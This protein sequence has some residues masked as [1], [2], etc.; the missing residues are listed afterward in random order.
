V[1]WSA[2]FPPKNFENIRPYPASSLAAGAGRQIRAKHEPQLS[3]F[4]SFPKGICSRSISKCNIFI[5]RR[6]MLYGEDLQAADDGRSLSDSNA[7]IDVLEPGGY[8]RRAPTGA[9]DHHPRDGA[10]PLEA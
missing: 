10:Q 7:V 2:F 3:F 5:L 4:L 8:S 6:K 9:I 1:V